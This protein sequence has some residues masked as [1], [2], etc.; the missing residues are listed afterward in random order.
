MDYMK[1]YNQRNKKRREMREVK[2]IK[3][4][5]KEPV[6]EKKRTLPNGTAMGILTAIIVVVALVFAI[7]M[8]SGKTPED[9]GGSVV[10]GTGTTVVV[11]GDGID[12]VKATPTPKAPEKPRSKAVALTFD[13]GPDRENTPKVLETLKEYNAHATFFVVGNRIKGREDLIRQEVEA[14]CEVA[15]HSWDHSNL[16]KMK[17]KSVNRQYDKTFQAVKRASGYEITLLRPPYGAISDRMRK[18]FKHPMV[19]WSVDTEDWKTK[20]GNK[21]FK[22]FCKDVKD[23]DIVLMHDI[24]DSTAAAIKKIIP[25]LIKNDYDILTV[26]ELMERNGKKMKNGIAYGNAR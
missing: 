23:G 22:K 17:M 9:A 5:Q 21:V 11:S 7:K 16:A 1:G 19:L 18:H 10:S 20:S 13:D 8:F 26:S 24:Q 3:Y 12:V 15:N 6:E 2:E 14:G 4:V 25:W